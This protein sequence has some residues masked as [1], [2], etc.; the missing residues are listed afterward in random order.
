MAKISIDFAL[1]GDEEVLKTY[2][3]VVEIPKK[4]LGMIEKAVKNNNCSCHFNEIPEDIYNR[5]LQNAVETAS[6]DVDDEMRSRY[7]NTS[8]SLTEFLPDDIV[9]TFDRETQLNVWNNAIEAIEMPEDAIEFDSFDEAY[10]F[11][12][13]CNYLDVDVPEW[14]ELQYNALKVENEMEMLNEPFYMDI[15]YKLEIEGSGT[16]LTGVIAAGSVNVGDA[17]K[18]SDG[19]QVFEVNVIG[20]TK[21]KLHKIEERGEYGENVGLVLRKSEVIDSITEDMFVYKDE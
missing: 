10:G 2:K 1:F 6:R 9:A 18:V 7:E 16:V 13:A 4:D 17:V 3:I 12:E 8:V 11:V 20:V 14:A 15:G 21:P 5:I 19:E